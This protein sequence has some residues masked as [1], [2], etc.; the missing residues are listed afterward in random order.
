ME[1]KTEGGT[2]SSS[3]QE[4]VSDAERVEEVAAL[5]QDVTEVAI[6]LETTGLS[7]VED[8]VRVLSV[9]TG[10]ETFLIDAFKVDPSPV[11]KVL[12]DKTLYVHGAEFDLPFL[13]PP[14]WVRAARERDRHPPPLAGSTSRGVEREAKRWVGAGEALPQGRS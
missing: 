9:H 3:T 12:K 4:I 8:K 5:L 6:D 2:G 14:L 13:L 7:P 1:G 10:G 11:L